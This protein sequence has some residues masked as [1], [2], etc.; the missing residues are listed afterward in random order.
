MD[1]AAGSLGLAVLAGIAAAV[2]GSENSNPVK[3]AGVSF[4]RASKLLVII[5]FWGCVDIGHDFRIR[6]FWS[7]RVIPWFVKRILALVPASIDV[8]RAFPVFPRHKAVSFRRVHKLSVQPFDLPIGPG[9][10]RLLPF[11]LAA[12]R[13]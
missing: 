7:S 1:A 4:L 12:C 8:L 9:S 10:T 5:F 11:D 2:F 13:S 3:Q 6:S